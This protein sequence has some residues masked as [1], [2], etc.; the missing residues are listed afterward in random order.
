[1]R[2]EEAFLNRRVQSWKRLEELNRRANAGVKLLTGTEL[3]EYVR[4]YR[5]TSGDLAYM[6]SHSSNSD[7]VEYLNVIV[8]NAYGV[9]YRKSKRKMTAWLPD[10]LYAAAYSVR[11]FAWSFWLSTTI[12]VLAAVFAYGVLKTKPTLTH[13]FVPPGFEGSFEQWKKG[14]HEAR[15][16]DEGIAATGFYATN[17]PMV[18]IR[19]VGMTAVTGGAMG[20]YLL[21]FNGAMIGALTAEVEKTG[22]VYFLYSSIGPHGVSE[23]GG[24]LL[25]GAA[26]FVM[27]FA[28]ISPGNRRRVDALKDAG[29]A[30]F[31]MYMVAL[32]M[33]FIAAPIEGFFSFNPAIPQSV[34]VVATLVGITAWTS[35]FMFYG[36]DRDPKEGEKLLS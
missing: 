26:G 12:F 18:G 8:G 29:K 6:Q 20:A 33:I 13:H 36:R 5:Q 23:I 17:N 34:K 11:K 9:L 10:A 28:L 14:E 30:S 31:P 3:V 32:V 4:L 15:N 24:I 22:Q 25:T 2:N 1:M 19:T 21:W 27:G 35:F 16:A 7:V